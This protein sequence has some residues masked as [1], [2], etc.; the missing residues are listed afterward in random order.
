MEIL[1][2][3][4]SCSPWSKFTP[5]IPFLLPSRQSRDYFLCPLP[6]DLFSLLPFFCSLLVSSISLPASVETYYWMAEVSEF[7][8]S[9]A[10]SLTVPN[11]DWTHFR[12]SLRLR[13]TK[14]LKGALLVVTAQGRPIVCLH[15]RDKILFVWSLLKNTTYVCLLLTSGFHS[16]IG[17][18]C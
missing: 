6:L 1:N 10:S 15:P 11:K 7:S 5:F 14:S 17:Y 3:V 8:I 4:H 18:G 9:R 16:F 13:C 12:L 2:V